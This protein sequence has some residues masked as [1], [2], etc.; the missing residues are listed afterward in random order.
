M[1]EPAP[2]APTR[3]DDG[4]ADLRSYAAIGDGRT[5]ALVALDGRIDW[6]P[7]PGLNGVPAFCALLDADLGGYYGVRPVDDFTVTREYVG[8]TNILATTFTT[9]TGSMRL[10]D[11]LNVGVAGRL[12]WVELARRVEGLTGTVPMRA[13]VMPGTALRTA[14]PWLHDT[15]HGLV[16][17]LDG[18][19]LG[20]RAGEG[21]D[22]S[23][24]DVSLRIT[25]TATAGSRHVVGL[26]ATEKE[27][28]FLQPPAELD[29]GI[30]RTIDAWRAWSDQFSWDG[31][32]QDQVHRSALVLKLLLY[33]P[34][35]GMT[36]AATTSLPESTTAPKNWDYRFAWVRDTAYGLKAL[37]RFGLRE[38]THAA[39][40]WM[41]RRVREHGP[42]PQIFYALDGSLP[43]AREQRTDAPGWRGIGP[44][45]NGNAAADQLQLGIFGDL[46]TIVRLYVDH[47][48]V[49][50][51]ETGRVLA[52]IADLACDRWREPDAG[53]WELKENRHYVTSKLGAWEALTGAVRLAE[54]GQ[55]PGDARRWQAEAEK[56]REWVQTEGWDE[57]RQT[58]TWYPGSTELDA[59]ILLHA[60]SGF[61]RGDRMRSTIRAL[62]DQ[63]GSG[64]YLHRYSGMQRQEHAFA[65]CSF[66]LVS[67][68]HL[69]GDRADARTLMDELVRVL[70]N[71]VGMMAEMVD[72]A[73]GDFWGNLP[74]ALSHLAL[75]NA[76]IT[77][78]DAD[79]DSADGAAD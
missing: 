60:I 21:T 42:Q 41:L 8:A 78:A 55:I 17:R 44:V 45:V 3:D 49:L 24:E 56:I 9:A 47:G 61:E 59:S 26:V 25:F 10:T 15:V 34:T 19:T 2:V 35:G 71:D 54:V 18:L 37:F 74:Q 32:W 11:A 20:V 22:V 30:D 16:L 1:S 50:D 51:T 75:V 58:Y 4:D 27:P 63:L 64:P 65:A 28:L 36:A 68:L 62:R 23:T 33:A 73:T 46:F 14:S 6:L 52:A 76:A 69:T 38:E 40:S 12:P 66:W 70:P 31:P 53:M 72:P 7:L 67:A 79:G 48:H 29:A 5:M 13:V 39:M 43:P 77:L 57:N